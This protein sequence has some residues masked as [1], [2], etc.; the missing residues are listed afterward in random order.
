MTDTGTDISELLA[1]AAQGVHI[2]HAPVEAIVAGGT[3]RRTRRRAAGA[4]VV[5]LAVACTAGILTSV[6]PHADSRTASV[7]AAPDATI[8]PLTQTI[9]TGVVDGKPWTLS[10]DIWQRAA[11]ADAAAREWSATQQA[12]YSDPQRAGGK[13]GQQLLHTGWFF[14]NLHIGD[15]HVDVTDDALTA[16]GDRGVETSW[17][18]FTSTGTRWYVVGMAGPAVQTVTCTWDDGHKATPTLQ[19]VAGT[20]N[21]FFAIDAPTP[22]PNDGV[23]NCTATG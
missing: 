5:A 22:K 16:T 6:S 3:R 15:G 12:E 20:D 19:T 23:P 9:A 10:I 7:A 21:R 18:K 8:R 1:D 2:K 13:G 11:N 14:A 17:G 4:A